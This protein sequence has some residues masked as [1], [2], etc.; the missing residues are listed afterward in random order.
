MFFIMTVVPNR[1][2]Q[3]ERREATRNE[4][5]STAWQIAQE[6]G[7]VSVTLREIALRIGMKPPS[8]YS[9][10]AS[11][12]AIYDAMFEQAWSTFHTVLTESVPSFPTDPRGR[13]LALS[14]TYFDFA[15]GDLARHQLMDMPMLPDFT[16]SEDAYRPSVRTYATMRSVLR[17][18]GIHRKDDVDLFTA[19]IGGLVNQQLAN[20]SSGRRWAALLARAVTMYADAID[21]PRAPSIRARRNA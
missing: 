4:I 20:D 21:L 9:H 5:L 1:D 15:V 14:K 16:P 7:L 8:L 10:F 18:V 6:C 12:N 17:E 11:K 19:V 3:A 13:L 2:R